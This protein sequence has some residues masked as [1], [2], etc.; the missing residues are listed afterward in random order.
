MP[1]P[2]VVRFSL[3]DA[4]FL[5][6]T[7]TVAARCRSW[8]VVRKSLWVMREERRCGLWK[9][10][11]IGDFVMLRRDRKRMASWPRGPRSIWRHSVTGSY[12]GGEG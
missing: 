6:E 9:P 10:W 12:E 4:H 2:L 7:A 1:K 8:E 5:W 3:G 11:T